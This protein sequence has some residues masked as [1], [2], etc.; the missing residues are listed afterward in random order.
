MKNLIVLFASMLVVFA[1]TGQEQNEVENLKA[2]YS[3]QESQGDDWRLNAPSSNLNR[4]PIT[5]SN[6]Y[7]RALLESGTGNFGQNPRGLRT[8]HADTPQILNSNEELVNIAWRSAGMGFDPKAE[9]WDLID[10][11]TRLYEWHSYDV[12]SISFPYN[13]NRPVDSITNYDSTLNDTTYYSFRVN[14]KALDTLHYKEDTTWKFTNTDTSALPALTVDF[15]GNPEDPFNID[16]TKEYWPAYNVYDTANNNDTN[17]LAPDDTLINTQQTVTLVENVDAVKKQVVDT[18]YY[19]YYVEGSGLLPSIAPGQEDTTFFITANYNESRGLGTNAVSTGEILLTSED[20]ADPDNGQGL[21]SEA[22]DERVPQGLSVGITLTFKPGYEVTGND[23]LFVIG[24]NNDVTYKHNTFRLAT[25]TEINGLTPEQGTYNHAFARHTLQYEPDFDIDYF[26]DKYFP[27]TGDFLQRGGNPA[28]EIVDIFFT[29]TANGVSIEEKDTKNSVIKS[30][31]PNPVRANNQ[32][33]MN[34]SLEEASQV[35][36]SIYN[37]L[38]QQ[39]D[40]LMNGFYRSGDHEAALKVGDLEPG[41]YFL[42]VKTGEQT[43]TQKINI[44]K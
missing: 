33:T 39:V 26:E 1:S 28:T 41:I 19:K 22:I 25:G 20:V 11:M 5:N 43:Q 40:E 35:N 17:A 44:V 13:Y 23:T 4:P 10:D 9:V 15:Y 7:F 21:I 8:T 37:S 34:F 29:I 32:S 6:N 24:D 14:G 27:M 2:P 36:V 3:I 42:Q 18:L 12:D 30:I 38:G 31:Y 16:S